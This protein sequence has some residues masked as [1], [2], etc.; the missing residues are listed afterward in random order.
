MS[1][2][3]TIKNFFFSSTFSYQGND[4]KKCFFLPFL[5]TQL[6][7]KFRHCANEINTIFM[8]LFRSI[9]FNTN[10]SGKVTIKTNHQGFY[11]SA[12]IKTNNTT[13]TFLAMSSKDWNLQTQSTFLKAEIG[14]CLGAK[15]SGVVDYAYLLLTSK[16][17]LPL[18]LYDGATEYS[19]ET[20]AARMFLINAL[21]DYHVFVDIVDD[22]FEWLLHY[23]KKQRNTNG[24][25][26]LDK[27]DIILLESG[28]Q[29]NPYDAPLSFFVG[30]QN[31]L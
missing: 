21:G 12:Q 2:F 27:N 9:N 19:K 22:R 4:F 16:H 10:T 7:G 24:S 29:N 26:T 23:P 13:V 25:L 31:H 18:F 28:S 1:L 8:E 17:T 11:I 15:D 5:E 14:R 6:K 30:L 20:Q 3:S